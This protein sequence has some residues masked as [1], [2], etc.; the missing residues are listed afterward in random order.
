[1]KSAAQLMV[2]RLL[3]GTPEWMSYAACSDIREVDFTYD[4]DFPEAIKICSTCPVKAQCLEYGIE[5]G[6]D[7]GVYGGEDIY[8][9]LHPDEAD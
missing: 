2:E 1:M 9:Y 4:K 3:H 8:D 5:T 6:T 7:D